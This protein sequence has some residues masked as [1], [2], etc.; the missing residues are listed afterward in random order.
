LVRQHST[1]D[2]AKNSEDPLLV[3]CFCICSGSAVMG[4]LLGV[5]R[6]M[7]RDLLSLLSIYSKT[8]WRVFIV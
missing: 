1:I 7:E 4:D 5:S 2:Y 6:S 8:I 3:Y